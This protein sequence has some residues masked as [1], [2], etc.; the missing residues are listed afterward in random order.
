MNATN[1]MVL[2]R[3]ISGLHRSYPIV[4][5]DLTPY[6]GK[7]VEGPVV[8]FDIYI[9]NGWNLERVTQSVSVRES[10]TDWSENSVTY[11][12]FGGVGFSESLHTGT[13]LTTKNVTYNGITEPITFKIPALIVQRWIDDPSSNRGLFLV[14]NTDALRKDMSFWSKETGSSPKLSLKFE[15]EVICDLPDWLSIEPKSGE[16]APGQHIALAVGLHATNLVAGDYVSHELK[17]YSNDPD[18]EEINIPISMWVAPSGPV[19]VDE[20]LCSFGKANELFWAGQGGP[21]QYW[22]EGIAI[23]HCA[24]ANGLCC[25]SGHGRPIPP[26]WLNTNRFDS[27]WNHYSGWISETNHLFYDLRLNT[28]YEYRIKAGVDTDIGW[29]ES[30]WSTPVT[31]CQIPHVRNGNEIVVPDEWKRANSMPLDAFDNHADDDQ[32]GFCNL[33]EY[34]TGHDPKNGNS[35]FKVKGRKA[36]EAD[37]FFIEWDSVPG[38]KYNIY[39]TGSLDEEFELI[40]SGIHY[41]QDSFV[42]PTINEGFYRV[43]VLLDE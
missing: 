30:D 5:F 17:L 42:D 36:D 29:L 34:I 26:G 27:S 7:K 35:S 11:A 37:A 23:E 39:W 38:R 18:N 41:P 12:N 4:Q 3:G 25:E 32:D 20:P 9:R 8:D 13:N 19:F 22:L 21:V 31:S 24:P 10:L 1:R 43:E 16:I 40:A 33:D 15:D 2:V 14:S 6:A 28:K